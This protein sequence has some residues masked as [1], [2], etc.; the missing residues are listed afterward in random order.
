[1]VSAQYSSAILIVGISG[2]LRQCLTATCS[3]F[4]VYL[5]ILI[6]LGIKNVVQGSVIRSIPVVGTLW[7]GIF[8]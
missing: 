8:V 6:K 4:S 2:S 1:M 7:R 5:G 3:C